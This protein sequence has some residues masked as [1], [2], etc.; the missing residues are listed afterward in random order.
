MRDVI[1]R[2]LTANA[3]S[4]HPMIYWGIGAVW[5]AMLC[6]AFF[7]IRAQQIGLAAKWFWL[8]VAIALPI[9]GLTVYLLWCLTRCDYSFMKPFG[10][11]RKLAGEMELQF[12]HQNK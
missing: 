5:L 1:I 8:I 4:E 2:F 3:I 10:G 12:R 9:I 11:G 6:N 7:S